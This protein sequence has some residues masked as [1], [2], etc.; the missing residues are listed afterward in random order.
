MNKSQKRVIVYSDFDEKLKG[1]Y[2]YFPV[3]F[4]YWCSIF[5]KFPR[6]FI[7]YNLQNFSSLKVVI[8]IELILSD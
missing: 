1:N 4:K 3:K 2:N 8:K 7:K 6:N 5:L